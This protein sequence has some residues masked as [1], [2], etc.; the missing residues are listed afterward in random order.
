MSNIQGINVAA[1]VVPYTTTDIFPTHFASYGKGGWRTVNTLVDRDSIPFDRLELSMIVVVLSATFGQ[2]KK[3]ELTGLVG[4]INVWTPTWTELSVAGSVTWG[5]VTGNIG[6]QLDLATYFQQY[7]NISKPFAPG[8]WNVGDFMSYRTGRYVVVT[9][10]TITL[11]TVYAGEFAAFASI[12][13]NLSILFNQ[14][15]DDAHSLTV[16]NNVA[17]SLNLVGSLF[18]DFEI[19]TNGP[20]TT[21][22]TVT[23]TEILIGCTMT[24]FIMFYAGQSIVLGSGFRC[25]TLTAD[26]NIVGAQYLVIKF[27]AD[28]TGVEYRLVGTPYKTYDTT[29]LKSDLQT[30]LG[31][32]VNSTVNI[33]ANTTDGPSI[34]GAILYWS[35]LQSYAVG[36]FIRFAG[37]VFVATNNTLAGSA[38][39]FL[40]SYAAN[41]WDYVCKAS[42]YGTYDVLSTASYTWD[43][44]TTPVINITSGTI[45]GIDTTVTLT[46]VPFS[47]V[48]VSLVYRRTNAQR[49]F[50]DPAYFSVVPNLPEWTGVEQMLFYSFRSVKFYNKLF[51]TTGPVSPPSGNPIVPFQGSFD[52][53]SRLIQL[54]TNTKALVFFGMDNHSFVNPS[55]YTVDLTVTPQ[56]ITVGPELD[57]LV[58]G[59]H[60]WGS[61]LIAGQN[62]SAA[63]SLMLNNTKLTL[64]T[65]AGMSTV[66]I[67]LLNPISAPATPQRVSAVRTAGVETKVSWSAVPG[68]TT[69]LVSRSEAGGPWILLFSVPFT[70]F[71]DT[72]V[73]GM[74]TTSTQY[75]VTSA[76]SFGQSSPSNPVPTL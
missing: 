28:P 68:T 67:A 8:V 3:Y 61:V 76:N 37:L 14:R 38:T 65:G 42:T 7:E 26:P 9:A 44:T 74:G 15:K 36:S 62:I 11:A 54:P 34:Q 59:D 24:M 25:P 45:P 75:R 40:I 53:V 56:T 55:N 64:T 12:Q 49:I 10:F 57:M 47:G 27:V 23:S 33:I 50:F 18:T 22:I 52:A 46:G 21:A 4:D 71:D 1:P 66:D 16:A 72:S 41:N 63:P 70:Y 6:D 29:K 13:S 31:G 30:I 5:N 58:T 73:V 20:T 19:S 43:W 32:G 2:K 17:A 48:D 51:Y 60:Y 39:S 35:A 69:Y